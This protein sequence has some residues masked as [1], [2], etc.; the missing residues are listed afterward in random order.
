MANN[1]GGYQSTWAGALPANQPQVAA[2]NPQPQPA[3]APAPQP[4]AQPQYVAPMYQAMPQ[5]WG[6]MPVD[7]SLIIAP[8]QSEEAMLNYIVPRG[9][10]AFLINYNERVF[11]KKRQTDDGLG[12]D[13]VRH[14][15]FTDEEYSNQKNQ[16]ESPVS[17]EEF[18]RLE[19][20]FNLLRKD[21]DDFMK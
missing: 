20:K 3:Q 2:P 17:A 6:M 10:T 19:E 13:I 9:V 21:F 8:V 18:A 1:N 16:S 4:M 14:R 11:W 12:Y 7:N 15:F 5:S